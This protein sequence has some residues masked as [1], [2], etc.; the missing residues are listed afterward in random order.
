MKEEEVIC[1]NNHK[2]VDRI[3]EETKHTLKRTGRRLS[4]PICKTSITKVICANCK[5]CVNPFSPCEKCAKPLIS[6]GQCY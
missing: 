3:D 2:F 6:E 4:C 1:P 5:N